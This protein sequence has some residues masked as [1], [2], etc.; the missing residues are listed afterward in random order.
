MKKNWTFQWQVARGV[1]RGRTRAR[2]PSHSLSASFRMLAVFLLASTAA[3]CARQFQVVAAAASPEQGAPAKAFPVT[4]GIDPAI[5]QGRAEVTVNYMTLLFA[6]L[7][8]SVPYGSSLEETIRN[9]ATRS[10]ASVRE[11]TTCAE[12]S[13]ALVKIQWAA[14]PNLVLLWE[15]EVKEGA[16]GVVEFPLR[17][18]VSD[19]RGDRA[20]SRNLVTGYSG[21]GE[22]PGLFNLP[23]PDDFQP[24]IAA[25]LRDTAEKLAAVFVSIPTILEESK[26]QQQEG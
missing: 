6:D 1:W 9:A 15:S 3:G 18:T 7:R 11:G 14:E 22:T 21:K 4:L 26:S 24:I 10:F 12:D 5:R 2:P 23:G 8:V 19:C 17:V 20:W 25:A 13:V 16:V